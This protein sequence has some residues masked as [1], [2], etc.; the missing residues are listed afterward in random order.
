MEI[1]ARGKIV[2]P[3]SPAGANIPF[4][5]KKHCSLRLGV[6]YR[7][8]K[9]VTKKNRY[10]LPRM[11][12]LAD[13]TKGVS[14]FTKIYQKNA[15]SLVRIANGEQWKTAFRTKYGQFEYM[16]MSSGLTNAPA[17]SQAAIKRT[18]GDHLTSGYSYIKMISLSTPKPVRNTQLWLRKYLADYGPISYIGTKKRLYSSERRWNS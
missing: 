2:P 17:S 18:F 14:V 10:R 15:C 4:V 11:D 3:R 9:V 8:L 12:E 16:V 7:A 13:A 5:A 6:D 1:I